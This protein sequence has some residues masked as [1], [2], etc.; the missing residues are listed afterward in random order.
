[1]RFELSNVVLTIVT[2]FTFGLHDCP[3][4]FRDFH[5]FTVWET[6]H[7]QIYVRGLET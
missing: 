4:L 1:M 7:E 3:Q 5:I 2:V 6:Y